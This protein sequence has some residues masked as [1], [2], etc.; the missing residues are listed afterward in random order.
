MGFGL[1]PDVERTGTSLVR[2]NV[3]KKGLVEKAFSLPLQY[4][5]AEV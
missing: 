1:H 2:D 5:S 4:V 3:E